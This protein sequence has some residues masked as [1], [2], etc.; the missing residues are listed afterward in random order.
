MES[1]Y[2]NPT[3]ESPIFKCYNDWFG[4]IEE[5]FY[6]AYQ[7]KTEKHWTVGST[8]ALRLEDAINNLFSYI[9]EHRED[10]EP[11]SKF[12]IV[13]VDGTT[14]K[15]DDT[16]EIKCYSISMKQAKQFKLI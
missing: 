14:D 10:I 2:I 5:S 16:R 3:K 9:K 15:Y 13:M 11:K 6:K 1:E 7:I 4:Y 8:F 12:T